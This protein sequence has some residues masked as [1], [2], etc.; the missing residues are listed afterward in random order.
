MSSTQV[1]RDRHGAEVAS[2]WFDTELR[3]WRV[4]TVPV[5]SFVTAREAVA[6]YRRNC[7]PL[8]GLLAPRRLALLEMRRGVHKVLRASV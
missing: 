1:F 7:D 2:A 4:S 5:R 8:T 6:F 3:K